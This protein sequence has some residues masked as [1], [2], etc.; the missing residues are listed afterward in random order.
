MG[1]TGMIASMGMSFLGTGMKA[2]GEVQ[3]GN[4]QD[5]MLHRNADIADLQAKDALQRGEIDQKKI[6]RRTE[7]VIG[8][9]RVNLAA[10][11]VDVNKGSSLD[12]VA[13]AAY[14]GKLD[15]L[16]IKNNA[17]KEAWGY[18][19]QADDLRYQGR[20]AKKKGEQAAFNTILG[21]AG[22]M[23]TAKYGS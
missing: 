16:T 4:A 21:G 14:L 10:Q 23:L 9:Q 11:G 3:A 22:S 8:S 19:T 17:A 1:A 7:Q 2:F 18:R 5:K 13:D 6:R 20:L 15:E 12:V